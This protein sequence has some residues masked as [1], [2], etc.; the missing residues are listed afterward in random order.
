MTRSAES[1]ESEI[2]YWRDMC[3]RMNQKLQALDNTPET[4]TDRGLHPDPTGNRAS[5]RVDRQRRKKRS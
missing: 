3:L 1:Y 5:N 4:H 2:R